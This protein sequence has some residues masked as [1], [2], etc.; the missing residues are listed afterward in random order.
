[1]ARTLSALAKASIR[2]QIIK[3]LQSLGIRA[4][5]GVGFLAFLL[6]EFLLRTTWNNDLERRGYARKLLIR[7]GSTVITRY[8]IESSKVH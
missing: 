5:W 6:P 4:L 1:M 8:L 2:V 7:L 3:Y